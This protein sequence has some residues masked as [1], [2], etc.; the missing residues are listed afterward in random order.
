MLQRRREISIRMA[1]GAQAGDIL[2]RVTTD[3]FS[4][5]FV[6]ALA[7]L[8]LGMASVRYIGTL[9]YQV[10]P[11]DLAMLA[12]PSLAV[13]ATLHASLMARLDRLGTGPKEVAQIG[14]AIGREF[15]YELLILV[16]Q[17]DE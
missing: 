14:A 1:I 12:L 13:P 17:K 10:K 7:G 16:A 9:L 8:A 6:G 4:T 2:R 5:V 11:T 3:V 15:S